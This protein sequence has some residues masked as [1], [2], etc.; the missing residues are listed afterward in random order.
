MDAA[1][2][3]IEVQTTR[4]ANDRNDWIP[5]YQVRGR[6]H[7]KPGMT[8]IL[9]DQAVVDVR[10]RIFRDKGFQFEVLR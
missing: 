6:L 10:L 5:P 2:T 1:E 4:N 3:K 8:G 9:Y 7:V